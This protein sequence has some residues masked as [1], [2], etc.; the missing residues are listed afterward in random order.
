VFVS[1]S[2]YNVARPRVPE[3]DKKS[4]NKISDMNVTNKKYTWDGE[5][6]FGSEKEEEHQGPGACTI[7]LLQ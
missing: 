7:K 6:W 5:N 3:T 2:L 4:L 1:I